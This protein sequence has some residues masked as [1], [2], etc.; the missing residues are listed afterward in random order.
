MTNPEYF[1]GVQG[2]AVRNLFELNCC[3]LCNDIAN[4]TIHLKV[5]NVMLVD[6]Y[7]LQK[8]VIGAFN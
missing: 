6:G 3:I 2:V 5:R 4:L 7:N 1:H 8:N